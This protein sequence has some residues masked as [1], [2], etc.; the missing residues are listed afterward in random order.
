MQYYFGSRMV[1]L[2]TAAANTPFPCV[3]RSLLHYSSSS[4]TVSSLLCEPWLCC[5]AVLEASPR[6]L[7]GAVCVSLCWSP[8]GDRASGVCSSS[9]LESGSSCC[10]HGLGHT[11]GPGLKAVMLCAHAAPSWSCPSAACQ[12]LCW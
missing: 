8:G 12:R 2:Y 4:C 10:C 9:V 5:C 1:L 11:R 6:C 3:T 7:T